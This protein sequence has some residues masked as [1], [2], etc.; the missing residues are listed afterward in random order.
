MKVFKGA[1]IL[2]ALIGIMITATGCGK[3]DN[4]NNGGVGG[5]GPSPYPYGAYVQQIGNGQLQVSFTA[6]NIYG[7][8]VVISGGQ[9]TT[10][11]SGVGMYGQPK[12]CAYVSMNPVCYEFLNNIRQGGP[13]TLTPGG[14]N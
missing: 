11:N 6:Q 10:S 12:Y 3:K 8:G 9:V 4:G 13:G 5:P 7:N 2:A 14:Y 1:T